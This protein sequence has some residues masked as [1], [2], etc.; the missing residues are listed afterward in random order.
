MRGIKA[1]VTQQ[2][3]VNQI[4]LSM[5]NVLF[6]WVE[7]PECVTWTTW[8]ST[9]VPCVFFGFSLLILLR[10]QFCG[11]ARHITGPIGDK[12]QVR[13]VEKRMSWGPRLW[14]LTGAQYKCVECLDEI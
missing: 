12:M 11:H 4:A 5:S 13:A 1:A 6:G 7:Y 9:M 10:W 14:R 3:P 2:A 8:V